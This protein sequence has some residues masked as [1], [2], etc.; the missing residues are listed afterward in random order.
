MQMPVGLRSVNALPPRRPVMRNLLRQLKFVY[1][2]Q[3]ALK[4]ACVLATLVSFTATSLGMP[5]VFVPAEDEHAPADVTAESAPAP[6]SCCAAKIQPATPC[7][8]TGGCK[9]SLAKRRA[10]NCCC[11]GTRLPKPSE[12]CGSPT[13]CCSQK[14][15]ACSDDKPTYPVWQSCNCGAGQN[16]VILALTVPK[17]PAPRATLP[18]PTGNEPLAIFSGVRQLSNAPEPLTPPPERSLS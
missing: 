16:P 11:S 2:T 3:S 17:L 8:T 15:N 12:I 5:L 7:S 6:R 18:E 10:G 14:K 9:C 13:S 4:L 1:R